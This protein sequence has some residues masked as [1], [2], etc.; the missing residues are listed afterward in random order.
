MRIIMA[1]MAS[2][3]LISCSKPASGGQAEEVQNII[4]TSQGLTQAKLHP[5]SKDKFMTVPYNFQ[6]KISLEDIATNITINNIPV[7]DNYEGYQIDATI[8]VTSRILSGRNS[9]GGE[10]FTDHPSY[11]PRP[12]FQAILEAQPFD[13]SKDWFE[14]SRIEFTG[15]LTPGLEA[16]GVKKTKLSEFREL[17]VRCPSS[18]AE[19]PP[20]HIKE[21]MVKFIEDELSVVEASDEH[22]FWKAYA[23]SEDKFTFLN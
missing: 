14:V 8:P 16:T 9:F 22:P 21:H 3:V 1:L 10:L 2:F 15:K 4:S 7:L 12:R 19:M 23:R 5:H 17:S 6:V 13:E 11:G 20:E 18:Y